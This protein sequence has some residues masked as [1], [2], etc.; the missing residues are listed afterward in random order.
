MRTRRQ[1]TLHL[2]PDI[3]NALDAEAIRRGLNTSRAANDALR[4]ALLDGGDAAIADMVKVRL[5]RLDKR[6][7][8]RARELATIKEALLLF[9]RVWLDYAGPLE[10]SDDPDAEADS[11]A[12]FEGFLEALTRQA[13]N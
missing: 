9:V 10:E 12:R 7:A 13:G 5:D 3:A 11:E 4:R 2:D 6:D 8:A 1:V